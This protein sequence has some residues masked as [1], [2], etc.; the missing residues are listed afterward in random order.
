M[1]ESL[2]IHDEVRTAFL[3]PPVT[4]GGLPVAV[5][6][7]GHLLLLS[8]KA[9]GFETGDM[10]TDEIL[11]AAVIFTTPGEE[12]RPLFDWS[13]ADWEKARLDMACRLPLHLL[14]PFADAVGKRVSDAMSP[15]IEGDD[16]QKKTVSAGG[17]P[18]S[19]SPPTNTTGPSP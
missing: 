2:G 3:A 11:L 9:P 17:S 15:A 10:G 12:L 19:S 14:R 5:P 7:M 16:G 1:S 4:V 18:S 8:A 6:C 13:D